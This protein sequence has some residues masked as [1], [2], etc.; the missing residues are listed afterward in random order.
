[1]FGISVTAF[2]KYIK[3]TIVVDDTAEADDYVDDHVDVTTETELADMPQPMGFS[4]T[5]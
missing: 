3:F 5:R 1:M 4:Q 2:G